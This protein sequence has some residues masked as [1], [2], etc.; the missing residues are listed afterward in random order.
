VLLLLEHGLRG[1]NLRLHSQQRPLPAP[2]SNPCL[3]PGISFRDCIAALQQNRRRKPAPGAGWARRPA[4]PA[5]AG[6]ARRGA[7]RDFNLSTFWPYSAARPPER[8]AA[9]PAALGAGKGSAWKPWCRSVDEANEGAWKGPYWVPRSCALYNYSSLEVQQCLS[10]RKVAFFGDSLGRV[11][12][13]QV[14]S[15]C[16]SVRYTASVP[17]RISETVS[18]RYSERV[19]V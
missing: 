11:L 10:R 17:V 2:A 6:R 4:R 3:A 13:N 7:R 5:A 18:V 9:G 8:Q 12:V 14:L 19:S 15:A 1:R 16:V